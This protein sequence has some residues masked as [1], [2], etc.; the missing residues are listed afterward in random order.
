M[1]MKVKNF[2]TVIFLILPVCSFAQEQEDENSF[3]LTGQI[4][5]RAEYRN[6]SFFPRTEETLPASFINNRTRLSIDFK[7]DRL[8]M[9]ISAQHVNV[10]GEDAPVD[11]NGRFMLNEAWA[12]IYFGKGF[13]AQLGRQALSYDDER[14]LGAS[15]W[16]VSGRFHDLLKLGFENQLNKLHLV[17]AYNQSEEKMSGG[18]FY[19]GRQPY[20]NMQ[21][22]WYHYGDNS[23]PFQISLLLMNLGWEVGH[24][25]NP[26]TRYMQT[27][28]T[29]LTYKFADNFDLTGSFYLQTG[30]NNTNTE[31]EAFMGSLK[32]GYKI[33]PKWSVFVASD[34]LSGDKIDNRKFTAFSPVYGTNHRFYGTM[35]YF[36]VSGYRT[37]NPGLWDNQLGINFKASNKV[38]L[39]LN[40]HYFSAIQNR[41]RSLYD[42]PASQIMDVKKGLGSEF[43]FQINWT[44]MKDVRLMAGYSFMLGT[45][46]MDIV[47]GGDHTK[48]QD[49]GWLSVNINPRLL[50]YKWQ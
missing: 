15:D 5:P 37:T 27:F 8:D 50:F 12:K 28:G 11:R 35:D 47:K 48:W 25:D 45:K 6:G 21:T 34:Y 18:N 32:L 31:V 24:E 4:R 44:I 46:T 7:K 43:D 3:S 22:V 40:Y 30:K 14:I 13:F 2:L 38:E 9:K 26:S 36:Y 10:W 20:K 33:N 17:L 16:N 19:T 23:R 49:W 41:V 39:L 29:Y 42:Q 1:V